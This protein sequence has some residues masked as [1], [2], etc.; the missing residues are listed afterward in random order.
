MS[1]IQQKLNHQRLFK[2]FRQE[3]ETKLKMK[4]R[5]PRRVKQEET[6]KQSKLFKVKAVHCTSHL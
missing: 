6:Q 5:E 1:K 3:E 4:D 2:P